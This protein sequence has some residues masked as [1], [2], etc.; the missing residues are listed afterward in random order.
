MVVHDLSY[1][2]GVVRA[3]RGPRWLP[4]AGEC[5]AHAW[6]SWWMRA[7]F[8][9]CW[10]PA[11]GAIFTLYFVRQVLTGLGQAPSFRFLA[12]ELD[13]YDIFYRNG[14]IPLVLLAAGAG[15]G[16]ISADLRS[17]ALELIFSRAVT[18]ADYL[19]GKV[20]GMIGVLLAG[21]TLPWLVVWIFDVGLAAD[22][23]RLGATWDYP[24]R[25]LASG[26][27]TAVPMALV[28]LALSAAA[29]RGTTATIWWIALAFF[30]RPLGVVAA[31]VALRDPR[32]GVLS[33]I[34]TFNS[35]RYALW[36][37]PISQGLAATT[38]PDRVAWWAIGLLCALSVRILLARTRPIEVVA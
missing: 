11:V 6:R 23:T 25:I 8:A 3:R 29:G 22:T 1:R 17:H 18:R 33:Y 30:T 2:R 31:A 21:S 15:A 10:L 28:V 14:W 26:L 20:L 13:V 19:L 16:L 37:I 5:F 9:A 27:A 7:L 36:D 35:I 34:D 38:P 12:F 4:I 32:A 24:L